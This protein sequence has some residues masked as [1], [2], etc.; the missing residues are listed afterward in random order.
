MTP[1]L[2]RGDAG[3]DTA[4]LP[5]QRFFRD[6]LSKFVASK[7][8][9]FPKN[10]REI[11]IVLERRTDSSLPCIPSTRTH[12]RTSSSARVR[13]LARRTP[14]SPAPPQRVPTASRGSA[15]P[16]NPGSSPRRRTDARRCARGSRLRV[17]AWSVLKAKA[18]RQV[19]IYSKDRARRVKSNA[20]G[21]FCCPPRAS[22]VRF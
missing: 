7:K 22:P 15:L 20:R 6:V 4:E 8:R 3:H 14:G 9:R 12:R 1:C 11:A 19:S 5:R 17:E 10:A 13:K 21:V 2:P 18:T 16:S